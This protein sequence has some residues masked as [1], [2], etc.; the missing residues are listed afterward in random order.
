VL[1]SDERVICHSTDESIVLSNMNPTDRMDAAWREDGAYLIALASRVLSDRVEAEDVVQD[2]FARLA[3]H[4]V[5]DIEDLRGWLVVVVRRLALDRLKSAHRRISRPVDPHTLAPSTPTTREPDPADRVTLDDEVRQALAVV[6]DQLSPAERATFLLHDVFGI[7]FTHIAELVGRTSAACRQL[8]S[9]ARRSV[10]DSEPV[11]SPSI[12]DPQLQ[13]VVEDFIE[14]CAGGDL[15]ALSR[16]LHTEVSGWATI[17][18][19]RVGFAKG[20]ETVAERLVFF[21][22][23]R[24]GWLLSPLPLDDGTAVVATRHGEP[25]ALLRLN[26]SDGRILSMR[27]VPLPV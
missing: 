3:L 13:A 10:R 25:A 17:E 8:A 6:L 16:T 27:C 9:R 14:A 11:P 7:P 19:T 26:V 4:R 12:P 18:G 5:E 23:P 2:A 24:S 20:V 1:S 21:L 22:G 15:E